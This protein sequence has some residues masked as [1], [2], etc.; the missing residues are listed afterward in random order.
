MSMPNILEVSATRC[1]VWIEALAELAR[2]T[3]GH[4]AR[5]QAHSRGSAI[6]CGR[7]GVGTEKHR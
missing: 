6:I 3:A 7:A 4:D 2:T 5:G 1:R